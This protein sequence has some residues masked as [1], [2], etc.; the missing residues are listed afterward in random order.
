VLLILPSGLLG[1]WVKARDAVV[2]LITGTRPDE[3]VAAPDRDTTPLSA[4]V[5]PDAPAAPEPQPQ[6]EQVSP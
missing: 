2:G 1:L 3:V 4:A 6:P 5:Q